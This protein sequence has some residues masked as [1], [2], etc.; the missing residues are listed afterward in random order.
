MKVRSRAEAWKIVEEIFPTDYEKNEE[1]SAECDHPVYHSAAADFSAW[2]GD[3]GDQLEVGMCVK[4]WGPVVIQIDI[5]PEDGKYHIY[6]CYVDDGS[7]NVMK[8]LIPAM[9]KEDATEWIRGNGEVIAI[10]DVTDE[11]RFSDQMLQEM[12]RA[13]AADGYGTAT[14]DII[15]RLLEQTGLT[16]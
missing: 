7:D 4:G 12:A 16:K 10:K 9:S 5:D 14:T 2:I 8:I 15:T 11:Y 13:L 6:R 1:A 3:L